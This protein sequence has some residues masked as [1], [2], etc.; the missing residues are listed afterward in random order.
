M[1]YNYLIVEDDL[2]MGKLLEQ[3]L[4]SA[5]V[6]VH[7]AH[8]G[9]QALNLL[10][11]IQC[12]IIILDVNLPGIGGF[13][14]A[15]RIRANGITTPI[16]FLTAQDSLA[17]KVTGFEVGADDYLAKPFQFIELDV[18]IKALRRRSNISQSSELKYGNLTLILPTQRVT[19]GDKA[20]LLSPREFSLI[21]FL[22]LSPDVI[23][24]RRQI[25]DEIWGGSDFV[26]LNIVDQ[27]VSYLRKK[28]DKELGFSLIET[29]R[30][31]G[32]R[33]PRLPS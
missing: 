28:I 30:G 24:S 9:A 25:L 23:F 1:L 3:G 27:Y 19:I 17:D 8:D 12:E 32:Y 31:V 7:L 33:I 11:E 22:L 2:E 26:D 10:T 29:I 20:I 5:Q 4:K 21:V 15:R 18:R 14:L 6:Q 16:L 13:E